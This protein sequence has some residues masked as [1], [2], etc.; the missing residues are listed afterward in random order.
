MISVWWVYFTYLNMLWLDSRP[1]SSHFI[2]CV[3]FVTFWWPSFAFGFPLWYWNTGN[4]LFN[5]VAWLVSWFWFLNCEK[6]WANCA[7][8]PICSEDSDWLKQ[9]VPG[10]AVNNEKQTR[11]SPEQTLPRP[12]R[13]ITKEKHQSQAL[14]VG[15]AIK[16]QTDPLIC[17][18]RYPRLISILNITTIWVCFPLFHHGAS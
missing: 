17:L 6:C 9:L 13:K 3:F 1:S 8:L 18:G 16:Q 10:G 15:L 14:F 12:L 2:S 5:V 7:I 4:I 11:V